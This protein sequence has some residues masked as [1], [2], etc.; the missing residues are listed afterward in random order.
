[1]HRND[2]VSA[3]TEKSQRNRKTVERIIIT[4]FSTII[5]TLADKQAVRLTDFGTFKVVKRKATLG[6]NVITGES[7]SIAARNAL[8]FKPSKKFKNRT[9][10]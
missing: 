8:V 4:I 7:V 5:D 3:V 1:M 10:D 2:L 9:N 6:R